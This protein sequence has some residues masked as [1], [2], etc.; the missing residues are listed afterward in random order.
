MALPTMA[1][2][3]DEYVFAAGLLVDAVVHGDCEDY[4][5]PNPVLFLHRHAIELRLKGLM[6]EPAL[7]HDL[8]RLVRDLA[9]LA[10]PRLSVDLPDWLQLAECAAIDPGSTSFRYGKT[11]DRATRRDVPMEGGIFVDVR[12][13]RAV[14]AAVHTFLTCTS[15]YPPLFSP[16]PIYL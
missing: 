15:P 6:G 11:R 16:E 2:L 3:A 9:A 10:P 12:H 5:V 7:T 13:L 14:M 4:R 8:N 1:E